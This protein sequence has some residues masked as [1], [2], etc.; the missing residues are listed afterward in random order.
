MITIQAIV[1]ICL[2]SGEPSLRYTIT[3]NYICKEFL[4]K[5]YTLSSPEQAIILDIKSKY[6]YRVHQEEKL[7]KEKYKG[8]GRW[9]AMDLDREVVALKKSPPIYG[10]NCV[11]VKMITSGLDQLGINSGMDEDPPNSFSIHQLCEIPEL[12]SFLPA[13]KEVLSFLSFF[14][15]DEIQGLSEGYWFEHQYYD[16]N[17]GVKH[18]HAEIASIAKMEIPNSFIAE[19]LAYPTVSELNYFGKDELLRKLNDAKSNTLILPRLINEAKRSDNFE[20][21][22][23]YERLLENNYSE[24]ERLRII[25]QGQ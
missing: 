22:H 14:H 21:A 18:M 13:D 25:L 4:N 12:F 17:Y 24:M 19:Q 20:K 9:R 15:L 3:D 5:E 7:L 23:I 8:T 6:I 11:Q 16:E 2:V 1:I 10:G